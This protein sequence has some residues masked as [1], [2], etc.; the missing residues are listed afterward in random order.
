MQTFYRD[1]F[2]QHIAAPAAAKSPGRGK[3]Y[4]RYCIWISKASLSLPRVTNKIQNWAE[5]FHVTQTVLLQIYSHSAHLPQRYHTAKI[6]SQQALCGND[7]R[8]VLWLQVCY[9]KNG[10]WIPIVIGS[11]IKVVSRERTLPSGT[12]KA[13]NSI[14]VYSRGVGT[15]LRVCIFFWYCT[16]YKKNPTGLFL[17]RIL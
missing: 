14:L 3:K 12:G 4:S 11:L 2:L 6:P 17:N 9:L 5:S 1:L 8:N 7:P 13:K 15:E 16:D 10:S